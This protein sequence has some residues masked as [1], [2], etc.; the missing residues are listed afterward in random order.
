MVL[1][2][3]PPTTGT[4]A[5]SPVISRTNLLARTMSSVV[6]PRIL[7]GSRF[8]FLQSS[9][10][11]GT[12]EFT[13]FTIR[14]M[15]AS[16]QCLAQASTLPL[17]MPALVLS[18]SLR[19]CP[20]LRGSPAGMNTRSQPLS[21]S[22]ALSMALS[23]L[24]TKDRAVTLHLPSKCPRSAATP[25]AGTMAMF[26]SMRAS[27]LTMGHV[28]ISNA[29]GWPMPPA[30]PMTHTLKSPWGSL[31]LRKLKQDMAS[32]SGAGQTMASDRR[33]LP[34]WAVGTLR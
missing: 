14:P 34:P 28:A 2:A 8:F 17:A 16:G 21:A 26:R 33:L 7:R 29:S 13:G 18:K 1:P 3:W 19:S 25:A 27:S 9:H 23:S 24:R 31:A 20:G 5:R 15:T 22:P 4:S 11:A 12:T 10:M 32:E 30:P 6:M